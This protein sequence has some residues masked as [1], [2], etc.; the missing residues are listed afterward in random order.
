MWSAGVDSTGGAERSAILSGQKISLFWPGDSAMDRVEV[1]NKS[2]L[3][4]AGDVRDR[5]V[6]YGVE[7]K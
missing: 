4:V 1:V 6:I 5:H 7:R 3:V 2:E